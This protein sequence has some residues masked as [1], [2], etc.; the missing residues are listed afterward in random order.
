M[1]EMTHSERCQLST[2]IK[3]LQK[4]VDDLE[5][6]Y[7]GEPN[8]S[9]EDDKYQAL[10]SSSWAMDML[11]RGHKVQRENWNGPGQYVYAVY[12]AGFRPAMA[13]HSTAGEHIGW[14][15][16]QGDMWAL[17]WRLYKE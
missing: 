4:R 10:H 7:E 15:F 11:M 12:L 13:I 3:N 1:N 6:L 16:S 9:R 8:Y 5:R 2:K 17:D 14:V